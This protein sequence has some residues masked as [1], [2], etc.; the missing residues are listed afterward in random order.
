[1]KLVPHISHS[2]G[3]IMQNRFGIT[4]ANIEANVHRH[5]LDFA[6]FKG[7]ILPN[8]ELPVRYVTPEHEP[9]NGAK[10][11]ARF[12]DH[13]EEIIVNMAA[14]DRD[15]KREIPLELL[16]PFV[17]SHKADHMVYRHTPIGVEQSGH[18]RTLQSFMFFVRML[19]NN[20]YEHIHDRMKFASAVR[21]GRGAY[22]SWALLHEHGGFSHHSLSIPLT[23]AIAG[24]DRH[25][26]YAEFIHKLYQLVGPQMW[27]ITGKFLPT[28][29]RHFANPQLYLT[30]A[31]NAG[32]I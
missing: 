31:K 5:V 15:R 4:P 17:V 7:V 19:G 23:G 30:D 25:A 18:R 32:I 3:M 12:D 1:M 24:N 28:S 22:L 6:R 29:D 27:D 2:A 13:K 16:L 8:V 26:H 10:G 14:L 21:E 9:H 20:E 11:M